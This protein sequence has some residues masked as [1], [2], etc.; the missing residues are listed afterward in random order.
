[1]AEGKE[2]GGS[3]KLAADLKRQFGIDAK[4]CILGHLQRGGAPSARDRRLGSVMGMRAV[5]AL[6]QG[7]TDVMVGVEGE[8][9]LLV[10]IPLTWKRS[11]KIRKDLVEMAKIL[12]T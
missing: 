1:M 6:L 7:Y 8:H 3:M 10:P 4:V 2:S 5:E 12:A 9:E 11:A